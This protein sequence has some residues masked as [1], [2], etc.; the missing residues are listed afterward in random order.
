[1]DT[2]SEKPRDAPAFD[3]YP[4]RWI[5]GTMGMTDVEELCYFRLLIHS[6]IADG[7]PKEEKALCRLARMR[8]IPPAVLEKF[9]EWGDGRR[10]NSRLEK[11]REK[12]RHRIALAKEK[13][14]KMHRARYK[15]DHQAE[16]KQCLDPAT[17]SAYSSSQAVLEGCPPPTS[18]HSLSKERETLSDEIL[19][20]GCAKRRPTGWPASESQARSSVESAGVSPD[21]AAT[22]WLH[23]EGMGYWPQGSFVS[24]M[25]AKQGFKEQDLKDKETL[26]E[27]LAPKPN[28][29]SGGWTHTQ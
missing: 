3:F 8:K 20:K 28:G 29:N 24:A 15:N 6:W 17:S 10:R 1:M 13:S 26:A 23:Y 16:D 14:Q 4:E 7:L 5:A 27:R 18:H 25:K 11:E 12:Q 22:F 2:L 21:L 19:P 9:P